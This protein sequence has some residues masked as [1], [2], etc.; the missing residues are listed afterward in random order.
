MD[1]NLITAISATVIALIAL[2]VSIWQGIVNRDHNRLSVKPVLHFSSGELCEED[3]EVTTYYIHIE[4]RGLGPA[5]I[6]SFKVYYQDYLLTS[7][8]LKINRFNLLSVAADMATYKEGGVNKLSSR[9]LPPDS[10]LSPGDKMELL[11]VEIIQKDPIKRANVITDLFDIDVKIKYKSF[12][13]EEQEVGLIDKIDNEKFPPL[14]KSS[15]P[16][17]RERYPEAFR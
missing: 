14:I 5:I 9:T 2:Y 7:A 12:Y 8:D 13:E 16:K 6:K 1:I 17:I 15:F 11:T 4:N 3:S 10:M